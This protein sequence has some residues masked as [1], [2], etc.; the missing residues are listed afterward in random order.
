MNRL[1]LI[2]DDIYAMRLYVKAL[3]KYSFEVVPVDSVD[4]ALK[5]VKTE[6]FD[7]A[8]LDIMMPPGRALDSLSTQG[9]FQTGPQLMIAIKKLRPDTKFVALTNARD[10]DTE[11]WFKS[12]GAAYYQ[13]QATPPFSFAEQ[14]QQLASGSTIKPRAF[15]VHGHDK[16][17]LLELKNYLQNKLGFQ[18]PIILGEQPSGSRTII[19]KFEEH[20]RSVDCAFALLSPDDR[21]SNKEKGRARQNVIFE[22]GY[23]LGTLG[24]RSG[25]VFVLKKGDV[26][27]PSDLYGV[28]YIDVT[29]GI[30]SAGEVLRSELRTLFP[31]L[32]VTPV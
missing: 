27:I 14:M 17:L 21:R 22:L 6:A 4:A 20:A 26:E 3:Q 2:D 10:P 11:S 1:L 29:N 7:I 24:R 30:E 8:V 19:E 23:F 32:R 28:I 25:R 31:H 12:F 5:A 15:I 16:Q 13:K 18:E 9:G